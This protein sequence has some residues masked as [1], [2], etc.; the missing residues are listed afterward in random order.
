MSTSMIDGADVPGCGWTWSARTPTAE[1]V[2]KM[3]EGDA[4]LQHRTNALIA[5]AAHRN[6]KRNRD[7]PGLHRAEERND[8]VES[9]R[10]QNHRP[11][12]GRPAKSEL[13]SN[14]EHSPIQLRPRQAFS[15]AVPVLVVINKGERDVGW[16]AGWRARALP[17]AGRTLS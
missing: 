7:A 2:V 8:V 15:N 13:L 5:D 1:D 11:V 17:R 14:V 3:T 10:R 6:R 16:A 9:L 4:S 12:T